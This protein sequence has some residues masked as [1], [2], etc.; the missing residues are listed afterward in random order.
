MFKGATAWLYNNLPSVL[1]KKPLPSL[2]V[3]TDIQADGDKNGI[4]NTDKLIFQHTALVCG[5]R[6]WSVAHSFGLW[7]P[8]T[9]P[10]RE[11]LPSAGTTGQL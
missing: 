5:T 3:G 9:A 4:L 11:T 6:L 1:S 2:E 8:N 10:Q 7:L